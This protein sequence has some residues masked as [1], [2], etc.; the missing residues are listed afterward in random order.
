ML[1]KRP[2]MLWVGNDSIFAFFIDE[3]C[4]YMPLASDSIYNPPWG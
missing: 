4:C 1:D 2:S 3:I